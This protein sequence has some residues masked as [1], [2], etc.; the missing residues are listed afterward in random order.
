MAS[1]MVVRH[2][3]R[4]FPEWKA[5]YD[6][7]L[8]KRV[9]AGLTEKHLLRGADDPNEVI[10]RL[11]RGGIVFAPG[12]AG[13]VQE[14]F[15]AATMTFYGTAAS[16]PFVFLG[17]RFWTEDLPVERLLRPLLSESPLGDLAKLVYVTDDVHE[18]AALLT[19]D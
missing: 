14:V 15:Q 17:Q 16:G 18:A 12:R 10:L 4:N 13:T 9:E 6:A 1:Y 7:H 19:S 5:G 2:K 8:P 3:V 11:S